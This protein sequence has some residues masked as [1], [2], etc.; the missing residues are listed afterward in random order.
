VTVIAWDGTTLASDR[1]ALTAGLIYR[2]TKILRSE[3]TLI[4]ISGHLGHG[5]AIVEWL[6]GGR[7]PEQFPKAEGDDRAYVL[8]IHRDGLIERFEGVRFPIVVE[9][10]KHAIGGA[11]DF[12]VAAMYLGCDA[13][14]AVAVACALS[15]ECG[16]GIDSLTFE[17]HV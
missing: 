15:S 12:A 10:L 11:R 7:R 4:G 8:V 6:A 1:R 14:R 2:V 17:P 13:R 3:D 9:D 5:L 16:D